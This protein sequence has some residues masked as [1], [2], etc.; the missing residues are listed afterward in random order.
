MSMVLK[1]ANGNE[2]ELGFTR[3]SLPDIQDG[4]GDSAWAT[5]NFRAAS[6]DESW[7][8]ASPC[9][10]LFQF[11]SLA[12]WL[13][14]IA[15][16]ERAQPEIGELELLEPELKF[17]LADQSADEVTIRV[18]FHLESRPEELNVDGPTDEAD[19]LDI[20]L[21][22]DSI[23]AAAGV[24]RADI[25]KLGANTLKDD[26]FASQDEGVLGE[27]D[28]DLNILD[29]LEEPPPLGSGEGED[30]AGER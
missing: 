22:R 26:I 29:R 25:E 6:G 10:N 21:P 12:E 30:N 18:G 3:D 7:E 1:G 2:F 16:G 14:A 20:H 9:M 15:D 11:I 27:P 19:Y 17:S 24:L 23:H 8:E 28:A 5:V 13:E 4:F